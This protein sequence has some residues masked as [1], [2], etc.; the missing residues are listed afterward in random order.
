M[1]NSGKKLNLLNIFVYSG[2]VIISIILWYFILNFLFF[3]LFLL[4]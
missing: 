4:L 3:L 1:G 2:I